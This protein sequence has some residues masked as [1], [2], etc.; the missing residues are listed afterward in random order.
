MNNRRE[1][2]RGFLILSGAAASGL[3]RHSSTDG[4]LASALRAVSKTDLAWAQL[5]EILRR[6]K[7]PVFPKRDFAITRYGAVCDGKTD[8]SAAFAKAIAACS[9]AGGGRVVV[10]A[11]DFLTGPV[12]LK[13]NVNLHVTSGGTIKFSQDPAKYL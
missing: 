5:P 9:K 13:S 6:I 7:P 12:H 4:V 1:F 11:G 2:I 8:C 10:P 3:W